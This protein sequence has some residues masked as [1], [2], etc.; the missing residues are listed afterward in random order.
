MRTTREHQIGKV[1]VSLIALIMIYIMA[2]ANYNM[3]YEP[4]EKLISGKQTFA[5]T[6]ESISQNYTSDDFIGKYDCITLNGLFARITGRRVYNEVTL[7]NNGML[8]SVSEPGIIKQ[9]MDTTIDRI[10]SLSDF[11]NKSDIPFLFVL[12]P[13]KL[14][15]EEDI[16]PAG[17]HNKNQDRAEITVNG[18][19]KNK[20]NVLDLRKYI[21]RTGEDLSKY[22][23]R[24]DHHWNTDGAFVAFDLLLKNIE[25]ITKKQINKETADL[26]YWERHEKKDWF[27]GSRGKRVGPC[28]A[29]TDSLIWY[30]PKQ[31]NIMSTIV[32]H[33]NK[34]SKGSFTDAYIGKKFINTRDLYHVNNYAVYQT[35]DYPLIQQRNANASNDMK[36]LML[37]DSFSLPIK[38]FMGTA[39]T[40]V[41]GIDLRHYEASDVIQYIRWNKPDMV[42]L[43]YTS[44]NLLNKKMYSFGDTDNNLKEVRQSTV[45]HMDNII[46]R[47]KKHEYTYE[48]IPVDLIPGRTYLVSIENVVVTDGNSD[49]FSL[50]LYDKKKKSVVWSSIFDI[51]FNTARNESFEWGF[52]VPEDKADTHDYNLLLYS[53]IRGKT[54][55]IG[56]KANNIT[57]NE[58]QND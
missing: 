1:I 57:V 22:Y 30:T 48:T 28:F 9:E 47:P 10:T 42:I 19:I 41:D 12:A 51:G 26:A 34:I 58:E 40:E 15:I 45:C 25:K 24:T 18:L 32:P 16:L 7:L 52:C 31:E 20:I 53:G 39:F 29:G 56:I 11:L 35:G 49:G 2:V 50:V 44:D 38:A 43:L 4:T 8:T 55:G 21:A 17:T 13:H 54:D 46:I 3:V 27:L 33:Q 5:D 37:T 36:V 6:V 23:Y 14:A